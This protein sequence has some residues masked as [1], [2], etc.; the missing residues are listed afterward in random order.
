MQAN[1]KVYLAFFLRQL[2][3]Q[4]VWAIFPLYLA[5]I[6]ASKQW[7]ALMD[8]INMG[9]QFAFMRLV[10]RFN[11]A[12]IF[13]IGLLLSAIVFGIY[14]LAS[15]YLQLLPVQVTLGAA[16]SCLFVGSLGYLLRKN[17][18][19]GS[20]SGLLYSTTYLSGGI[21][22]FMGGAVSELWG[23]APLMYLS[24]GMALASFVYSRG[25]R[26]GQKSASIDKNT[27]K[28]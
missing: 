15:N 24:S 25:L 13:R 6:G 22:P 14:G 8:A 10:E 3:A 16:W 27:P 1:R 11:P 20:V 26:I 4:A 18:E 9:S 17:I 19:R 28:K 5:G 23:Y 21:G 2:G 12:L 7:I